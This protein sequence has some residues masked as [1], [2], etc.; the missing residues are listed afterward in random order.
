LR[1]ERGNV[2]LFKEHQTVGSDKWVIMSPIGINNGRNTIVCIPLTSG[3]K[4]FPPFMIDI[5]L[6]SQRSGAIV[7]Q[8]RALD[9]S[10]FIKLFGKLSLSDMTNIEDALKIVLAL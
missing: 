9:K 5:T 1:F 3:G 10:R 2:F 6:N 4:H 7:D 8:I